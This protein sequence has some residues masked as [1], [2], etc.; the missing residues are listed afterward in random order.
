[1]QR[2][3]GVVGRALVP[4]PA[5]R[6][7]CK[8]LGEPGH[9]ARFANPGLAGDQH[10]LALPF[11]CQPLA[12]QRE[13]NLRLAPDKADRARGA[14]GFEAALRYGSTLDRPDRDGL[15][16]TFH[17]AAAEAA[18]REQIAKQRA[19]RSGN[20]NRARLGQALES[21]SD[22]RCISDRCLL[23]RRLSAD[24]VAN[25]HEP[26]RDGDPH[27]DAFLRAERPHCGDDVEA[28]A[29]GAFRVI[30]V[31]AG[32]AEIG[33]YAVAHEPGDHAIV[34][35]NNPR[36]CGPIGTDHFPHVFGIEAR[37][38]RR[39]TYQIAEHDGE[40]T[41]LGVGPASRLGDQPGLIE[42]GDRAQHLATM[43]EQDP[44]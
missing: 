12:R 23:L 5:V 8:A 7:Q 9:E 33:E 4:H 11:P 36:A 25:H 31:R 32:I 38:E 13:C 1:M 16:D 30:L 21:G 27:L 42:F 10:H 39:R 15:A 19:R 28:R 35:D 18:K 17:L 40:V 26:G 43:P 29:H 24:E 6:P 22:V 3:V 14:N 34:R 20:D 44:K 37:R 41:P 2:T